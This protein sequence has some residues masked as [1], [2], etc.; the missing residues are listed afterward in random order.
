MRPFP[1]SNGNLYILVAINYI[2]KW[3]EAI[4][5]PKNDAKTVVKFLQ[6]KILTQLR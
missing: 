5:T 4:E 1:P 3:V 2:S 6:K